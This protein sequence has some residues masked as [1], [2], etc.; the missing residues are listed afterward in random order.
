[1]FSRKVFWGATSPLLPPGILSP[2][3][4]LKSLSEPSSSAPG[5]RFRPDCHSSSSPTWSLKPF[6][7]NRCAFVC[8]T[9]LITGDDGSNSDG[10]HDAK[11]AFSSLTHIFKEKKI[12]KKMKKVDLSSLATETI[13]PMQI[14]MWVSAVVCSDSILAGSGS[15]HFF[16]SNP[17]ALRQTPALSFSR[18]Q[19]HFALIFRVPNCKVGGERLSLHEHT[20]AQ[21]GDWRWKFGKSCCMNFY[22]TT[23]GRRKIASRRDCSPEN[24]IRD[25][26]A[27]TRT[28]FRLLAAAKIN[29]SLFSYRGRG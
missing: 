10:A 27:A 24:R 26:D 4:T 1:M 15:T 5:R 18:H 2:R 25:D 12:L 23:P 21:S 28:A 16:V 22:R 7:L 9:Y 6:N 14:A 3:V 13:N 17:Q 8:L 19:T 20:R 29:R 11:T